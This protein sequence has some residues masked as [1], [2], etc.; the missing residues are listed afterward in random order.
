[1]PI[2]N[3]NMVFIFLTKEN[4]CTAPPEQRRYKSFAKHESVATSL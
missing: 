2:D 4:S 3:Y 1:V